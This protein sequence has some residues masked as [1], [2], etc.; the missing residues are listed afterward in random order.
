MATIEAGRALR[1][2]RTMADRRRHFWTA[3]LR[4]ASAGS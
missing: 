1:Q 2:K 4:A 3:A